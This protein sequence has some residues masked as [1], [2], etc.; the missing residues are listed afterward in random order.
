MIH[1]RLEN[2]AVVWS[3]SSK[4]DIRKLERVQKITTKMV[5]ELK[6]LTYEERLKEMCPRTS[7]E[8]GLSIGSSWCI[9]KPVGLR[10]TAGLSNLEK[11][12]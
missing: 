6:D 11:N 10:D 4:S 7:P 8:A 12:T 5:P 3:Q 2:A 1:P 9:Q